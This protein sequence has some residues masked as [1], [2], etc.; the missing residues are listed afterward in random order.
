[1]SRRDSDAT[2]PTAALSPYSTARPWDL[3]ARGYTAELTEHFVHYAK[4]ALRLAEV[5]DG[6]RVLDVATGPGTLALEAARIADVDALDFSAEML[7][8]LR[9][10]AERAGISRIRVTHGDGQSL[11]FDEGSFDA[12]FSMFGLFMFPDRARGFAELFRVLRPGG[13]AVV[14]SWQMPPPSNPLSILQV[15]LVVALGGPVRSQADATP[16]LADRAVFEAEMEAAGFRVQVTSITHAVEA[17]SLDDLLASLIRGHA[18]LA[19]LAESLEPLVF[20]S[21]LDRLRTS[22]RDAVG[23]GPQRMEMP[24]WLALGVKPS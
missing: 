15:E 3:V 20:N 22:L 9:A 1:M 10:R 18:G 4:H 19:L 12:A 7:V 23:D 2:Q 16:S 24:A 11:P 17:R 13:R 21:F 8:S 6:E 5:C 14:S